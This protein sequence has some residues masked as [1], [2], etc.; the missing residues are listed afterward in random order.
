[1]LYNI[2]RL[3]NVIH[4]ALQNCRHLQGF[5]QKIMLG[6]EKSVKELCSVGAPRGG[7]GDS[8]PSP[9][10]DETLTLYY[11]TLNSAKVH[12]SYKTMFLFLM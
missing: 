9:L 11:A 5:I 3:N 12:F 4:T 2:H 6:G 10:L 1:M 7:L 8:P